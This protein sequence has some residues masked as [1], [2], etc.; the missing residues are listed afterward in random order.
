MADPGY[1]CNRHFVRL[2]EGEAVT[3]PVTGDSAYQLNSG[4][5]QQHWTNQTV[6]A[7]VASPSNPTGTLINQSDMVELIDSVRT[8]PG[9]F[10][11]G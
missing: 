1:P 3:I 11:G 7:L 2:L 9:I 5:I 4:H 10:A 6:A 8:K